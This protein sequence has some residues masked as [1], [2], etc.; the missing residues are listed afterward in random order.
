MLRIK[1]VYDEPSPDDGARVLVD[2]LWPR[3][4]KKEDARIDEWRK[5]LAPSDDLRKWY[6]H[7]REKWDEFRRRYRQELDSSG[8]MNG[9]RDLARRSERETVTLVFAAK[10]EAHA[11]A[12]ALLEF[13]DEM[14]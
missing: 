1:R 6:G 9:L 11:N 12:Q 2:R 10:D 13:A 14:H 7:D 5:D 8:T 4:V 3:G